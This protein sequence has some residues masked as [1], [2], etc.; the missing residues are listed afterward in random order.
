VVRLEYKNV[1]FLF[2]GDIGTEAEK[3]YMQE[4]GP[5]ISSTVLKVAHHGGKNTTSA[6][7]LN[8]VQ[9]EIAIISCGRNNPFGHP[10]KETIERLGK[11]GTEIYR[12][13]QKGTITIK[14][15]GEKYKIIT[16]KK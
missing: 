14:T 10:S 7:F 9:P 4:Y 5:K 13:D 15:N 6:D 3:F 11:T 2:T 16:A 8:Y 12:T 1:S